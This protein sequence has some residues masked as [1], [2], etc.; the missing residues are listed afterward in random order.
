MSRTNGG[1]IG[2]SL[3]PSISGGGDTVTTKNSTGSH[4]T[5]P[6]TRLARVL[7]VGGGGGG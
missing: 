7:V 5:Q 3:I 1:L 6:G 2:T 4:T